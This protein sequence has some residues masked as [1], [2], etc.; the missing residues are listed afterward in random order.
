[1]RVVDL[2]QEDVER[3]GSL[4]DELQAEGLRLAATA[5]DLS[6]VITRFYKHSPPFVGDFSAFALRKSVAFEAAKIMTNDI[7]V[8]APRDEHIKQAVELWYTFCDKD[9]KNAYAG[10]DDY[11]DAALILKPGDGHAV[12]QTL[13]N[14]QHLNFILSKLQS[15]VFVQILKMTP[16]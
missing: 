11:L 13:V 6:Q 3:I 14:H 9:N 5:S 7:Q 1:M 12:R 8:L 2:I 4:T 15:P 16:F 10:F